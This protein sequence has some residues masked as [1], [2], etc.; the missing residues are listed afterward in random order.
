MEKEI[1]NP[2]KSWKN[3]NNHF[4]NAIEN[5]WYINL[6]E[7][8]NLI[9][10]YTILFFSEINLKTL[11]MPI[12]TGSISSPMGLGSDSLPVKINLHGIDTYLADSMQFLLEY[13]TR[14]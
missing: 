2:P 13:A 4:L 1:I 14:I 8:E 6:I 12:T 11:H 3:I 9:T 5:E 7:L 10:K